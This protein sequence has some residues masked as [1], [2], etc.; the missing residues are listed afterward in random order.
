MIPKKMKYNL[1]YGAVQGKPIKITPNT[2]YKLGFY[3]VRC[4]NVSI[5]SILC[6]LKEEKKKPHLFVTVYV[7]VTSMKRA[8]V[9]KTGMPIIAWIVYLRQTIQTCGQMFMIDY[10]RRNW[11][12][13]KRY[14]FFFFSYAV[15]S[16]STIT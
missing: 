16:E 15:Y 8:N 10:N 3:A 4:G 9:S 2:L 1:H 13:S 11:I 12:M 14:S 5:S 7:C 6:A